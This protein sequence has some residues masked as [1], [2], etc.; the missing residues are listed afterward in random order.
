MR[1]APLIEAHGA[2]IPVLGL[3]TSQ[4]SGSACTDI[5]SQALQLG[6]RHIDTAAMYGNEA[7]VGEGLRRSGIQR[8]QIF[9]TTKVWRDSLSEAAA[10]ASAQ[11]S[12]KRLG[13]P[14]VDLLLIHWP[15]SD[16]PLRST[17]RAFSKLK[18]AGL[19]RHIGVSNFP[20]PLLHEAMR[21]SDVPLV[22]NQVECHPWLDQRNLVAT[23]RANGMAL[24][25]YFPLGR[26]ALLTDPVV[27][28]IAGA[29]GV[30]PAGVLLAWNRQS[31][32]VA[33]PKTAHVE[34]LADN[35]ASLTLSLH[36]DEMARLNSLRRPDGRQLNPAFAPH[37]D[38]A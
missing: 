7:E 34:R 16:V 8:S 9:L 36:P 12:L 27:V 38:K 24:T 10:M 17:L 19:T 20:V 25:A 13:V 15:N 2:R 23:C 4:L 3:G 29:R 35:F 32:F 31:G 1:T 22:T 26:G 18:A 28:D 5:V 30:S 6:Y 11:A 33:I 21:I 14:Y 37:W